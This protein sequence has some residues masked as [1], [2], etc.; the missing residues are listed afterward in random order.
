MYSSDE[1]IEDSTE[2]DI[3]KLVISLFAEA[4]AQEEELAFTLGNGTTQPTG[5]N[6]ARTAGTITTIAAVGQDFDDII[7]LEYALPA[8]YSAGAVFMGNRKSMRELRKL[9]D[10]NGRYLWQEPVAVGQ[11]ATLHGYSYYQNQQLPDGHIYFGDFKRAYWIGDRGE[12]AVKV[13]QDSE[14]AFTKDQTAIRVVERIAG[15][16]IQG[17]ALKVLTGF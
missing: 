8:K 12:M 9:K 2:F 3:V 7:N 15:A 13:T 14:T 16:V 5:I 17:A 10:T 11:P 6:T 1:L 4:I